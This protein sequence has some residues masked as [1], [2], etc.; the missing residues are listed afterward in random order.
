LFRSTV[1]E[2]GRIKPGKPYRLNLP[3][4]FAELSVYALPSGAVFV[5]DPRTKEGILCAKV[6]TVKAFPLESLESTEDRTRAFAEVLTGLARVPGIGLVQMSDQTTVISGSHIRAWYRRRQEGAERTG[7]EVDPFL[8]AALEGA[9]DQ[10]Q[11][12]PVHEMWLT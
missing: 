2:K 10:A 12:Q 7:A 4:E 9:M 11:G 6:S 1:T 3:G 8:H 5:W